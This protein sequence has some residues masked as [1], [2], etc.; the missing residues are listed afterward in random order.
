MSHFSSSTLPSG[1]QS[2][3]CALVVPPD[4]GYV[5]PSV[6][7]GTTAVDV[8]VGGAGPW[9][10]GCL[11]LPLS[12]AASPL[13]GQARFQGSWP[14]GPWGRRLVAAHWRT[15]EPLALIGQR[16][17][18]RIA[19]VS[20]SA[21]VVERAPQR[22][23]PVASCLLRRLS[24]WT[25]GS[26]SGSFQSTAFVLGLRACEILCVPFKSRSCFL[27]P[28]QTFHTQTPPAFTARYSGARLPCSGPLG[29]EPSVAA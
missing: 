22:E 24:R 16:E 11:S 27:Q 3:V 1:R 26:D 29:W 17:D 23:A 12:V 7:A 13:V 9:P 18:S 2:H 15:G 20:T 19:P 6:T 28:P 10:A 4:V 5:D 21:L 8:Q 14:W 25:D